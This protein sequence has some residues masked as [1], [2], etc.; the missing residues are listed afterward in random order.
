MVKEEIYFCG[1]CL[2]NIYSA[3][4]HQLLSFP[5]KLVL[6]AA[7]QEEV[8]C[9]WQGTWISNYQIPALIAITW[10]PKQGELLEKNVISA[11][12]MLLP[13]ACLNTSESRPMI[14]SVL[15]SPSICTKRAESYCMLLCKH[16]TLALA[17]IREFSHF[18]IFPQAAFWF[19]KNCNI[20][21]KSSRN[22]ECSLNLTSSIA[23]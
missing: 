14:S 3:T 1:C 2:I 12:E 5:S 22:N 11:K 8:Y 13:I 16:L 23:F 15:K 7:C 4:S 21:W 17:Q 6:W 19:F 9:S 10:T 18:F 20:T